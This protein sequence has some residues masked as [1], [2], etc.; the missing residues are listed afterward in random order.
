MVLQITHQEPSPQRATLKLE[1]RL[2][3]GWAGLLERECSALR[4]AG[5]AVSLDLTRVGF[6]DRA[7]IEVLARLSR[8]GVE[9]HCGP[10]LVASV[11]EGEGI[12]VKGGVVPCV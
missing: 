11:L 4:L 1:G 6:V 12:S 8:L 3:A 2:V 7:G 5:R 10:G 9:I